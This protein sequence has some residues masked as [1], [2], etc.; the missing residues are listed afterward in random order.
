MSSGRRIGVDVLAAIAPLIA[1]IMIGVYIAV[2]HQQAGEIA[3]WFVAALA[4]AAL[5]AVYGCVRSAPGRVPALTVAGV[6][7]AVLGLLGI[8]SIGLP[9][10]VAGVLSLIAAS[11]ARAPVSTG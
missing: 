11:R 7:M 5:L 1:G 6:V 8:L 9:I 3:G 4:L 2:I 10:I